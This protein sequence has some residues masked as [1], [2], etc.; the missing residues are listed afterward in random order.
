MTP[1]TTSIIKAES[2]VKPLSLEKT[3]III[4]Q[5]AQTTR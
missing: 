3:K 2:T 4:P 1:I 5:G